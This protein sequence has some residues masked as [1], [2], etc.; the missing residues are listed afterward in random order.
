MNTLSPVTV[1]FATLPFR[2]A[3]VPSATADHGGPPPSLPTDADRLRQAATAQGRSLTRWGASTALA[4][5]TLAAVISGSAFAAAPNAFPVSMMAAPSSAP[6]LVASVPSRVEEMLPADGLQ[7]EPTGDRSWI[8]VPE[9]TSS[10]RMNAPQVG[11]D[12]SI[13]ALDAEGQ[14]VSVM[15]PNWD[16]RLWNDA[17]A[18][19]IDENVRLPLAPGTTRLELDRA[20]GEAVMLDD[21]MRD[22][23]RM[24]LRSEG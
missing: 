9:G 5:G 7:R 21:E 19:P 15:E 4:A 18:A 12:G 11:N 23:G 2:P 16:G 20:R 1:P 10:V 6:Q 13:V 3:L 14:I 24:A 8:A 22:L 17:D